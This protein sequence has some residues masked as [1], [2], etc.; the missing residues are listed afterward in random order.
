MLIQDC[1][2]FFDVT[3]HN[4]P[5]VSFGS[6]GVNDKEFV[7]PCNVTA[8]PV[9]GDVFVIDTGNSRCER[10]RGKTFFR[11]KTFMFPSRVKRLSSNLDFTG[12]ITNESLEGRSVTG[13]CMGSSYDTLIAVNWRT[14]TVTEISLDGKST[15]ESRIN[16]E[17]LDVLF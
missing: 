7:Q 14:K 5:V 1:P 11:C 6:A 4:S 3:E 8:D 2:L 15:Q 13:L 12:H 17:T 10:K 16:F 9:K